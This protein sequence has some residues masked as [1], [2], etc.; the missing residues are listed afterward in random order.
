VFSGCGKGVKTE[1]CDFVL[2]CSRPPSHA[3][4]TSPS[5]LFDTSCLS[6]SSSSIFLLSITAHWAKLAHSVHRICAPRH[7]ATGLIISHTVPHLGSTVFLGFLWSQYM[8]AYHYSLKHISVA[9]LIGYLPWLASLRL[10]VESRLFANQHSRPP[11][12]EGF[13]MPLYCLPRALVQASSLGDHAFLAW[14]NRGLVPLE[15]NGV[16]RP[17]RSGAALFTTSQA[18]STVGQG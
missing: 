5:P 6:S 13:P 4:S 1:S 3:K 12:A 8:C 9:L 11:Q 10:L 2:P 7:H 14:S 18:C 15:Q 17:E 16:S